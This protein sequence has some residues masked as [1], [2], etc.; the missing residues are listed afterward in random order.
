MVFSC[1]RLSFDI[2]TSPASFDGYVVQV[3]SGPGDTSSFK[4]IVAKLVSFDSVIN[5]IYD[6]QP[7]QFAM[8][9]E[10]LAKGRCG[11][12]TLIRTQE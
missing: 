12:R 7:D 9:N 1:H 5:I 8:A 4:S 2:I 6:Y 10:C 11:T 3:Q